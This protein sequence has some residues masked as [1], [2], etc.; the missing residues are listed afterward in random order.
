MEQGRTRLHIAGL[1][2]DQP[3]GPAVANHEEVDLAAL[4][5]AHKE[6]FEFAFGRI[7]P[8]VARLQKVERGQVSNGQRRQKRGCIQHADIGGGAR[9]D[10]ISN[11]QEL[12]SD[13][14]AT[15]EVVDRGT[16]GRLARLHLYQQPGLSFTGHQ[17]IHFTPFLVTNV[18]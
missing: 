16:G 15:G 14:Q 13:A 1:A 11:H 7:G 10:E 8:V 12:V 6:K 18:V 4:F 2:F 5:V 17:E 9:L 3:R